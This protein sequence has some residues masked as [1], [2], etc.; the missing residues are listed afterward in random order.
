MH[1]AVMRQIRPVSL[2]KPQGDGFPDQRRQ[3]DIFA[4]RRNGVDDEFI[5]ATD[6]RCA[7]RIQRQQPILAERR[8]EFEEPI[9]L[10]A[11]V[12]D[13]I[14][15]LRE[16]HAAVLVS[17]LRASLRKREILIDCLSQIDRKC[18]VYGCAL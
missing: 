12:E 3:I 10:R 13:S 14:E 15:K 6:A 5:I 16:S 11:T 8:I 17:T 7:F 18:A 1:V 2:L 9:A 4:M